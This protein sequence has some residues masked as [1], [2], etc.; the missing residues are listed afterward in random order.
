[1]VVF[2]N[3]WYFLIA[4]FRALERCG[5]RPAEQYAHSCHLISPS[6]DAL[7]APF[8]DFAANYFVP[9]VWAERLDAAQR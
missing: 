9:A 3:T 4:A 7:A 8:A 5:L 1:V 2:I 6:L